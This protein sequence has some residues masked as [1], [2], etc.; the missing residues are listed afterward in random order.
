MIHAIQM[1]CVVIFAYFI[2]MW[3]AE[4]RNMSDIIVKVVV[5][6]DNYSLNEVNMERNRYKYADERQIEF[7]ENDWKQLHRPK[8]KMR[9]TFYKK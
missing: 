5:S 1:F 8:R 2:S 9:Q 4:N 6:S 3:N 7:K